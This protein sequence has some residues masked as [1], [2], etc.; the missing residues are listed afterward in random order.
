MGDRWFL[1]RI[2]LLAPVPLCPRP[3]LLTR[4]LETPVVEVCS[5]PR[6]DGVSRALSG[7][8]VLAALC[9]VPSELARAAF[10]ESGEVRVPEKSNVTMAPPADALTKAAH[11]H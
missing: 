7:P 1:A 4:A 2:A 3:G 8:W 11:I 6:A 5:L 10:E 9:V